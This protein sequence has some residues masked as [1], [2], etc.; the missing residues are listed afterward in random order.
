[1]TNLTQRADV[2]D[3][4]LFE[5]SY[6]RVLPEMRALSPDDLTQISIDVPSAIATVLGVVKELPRHRDAITKQL[7]EFDLARFERIEE[8]AMALSHANTLYATATKPPDDLK[9][10]Y[11][12][13]LKLRER[14]H[15]DTT[16]LFLRDLINPYGAKE[17]SSVIVAFSA[18]HMFIKSHSGA[19]AGADFFTVEVLRGFGLIYVFFVISGI[20]SLPTLGTTTWSGTTKVSV[21][22]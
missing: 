10:V 3:E 22:G 2:N 11:E 7:P 18:W 1:M 15:A 12:E 21:I 4:I 13:G 19:I 9:S 6:Q 16:T 8:Y 20:R 17:G 14:L 5:E